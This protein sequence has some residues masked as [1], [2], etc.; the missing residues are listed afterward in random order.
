MVDEAH[1]TLVYGENGGGMA[2]HFDVADRI[3]IHIGTL[4][5][6]FGSHG[7]FAAT[8]DIIR[9]HLLNNGRPY[10]Y[11]TALPLP[12]VACA[13]A[14]LKAAADGTLRR[15]LFGLVRKFGDE[16][17]V[18]VAGPIVPLVLG[19]ERDA[20]RAADTLREQGML[21]PAIRPPTVPDGTA[22][23][24]VT[25]S[26]GHTEDELERLVGALCELGP[27]LN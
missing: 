2:E 26:A 4:S 8:S 1:A 10:I 18:P 15:R 5:K 9:R 12:A 17:G 16:L 22:R 11:S 24:R 6:A 3:D 14:A 20:L 19:G 13:R 25:L 7:G 21:V 27:L 23:L